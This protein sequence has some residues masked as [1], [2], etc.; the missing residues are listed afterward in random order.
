MI[1]PLHV[2]H[3]L[4]PHPR[5]KEWLNR[6]HYTTTWSD[7]Q[8]YPGILD[9]SLATKERRL[10]PER[11]CQ[12]VANTGELVRSR[13]ATIRVEAIGAKVPSAK[14][15][16]DRQPVAW[17]GMIGLRELASHD[18][19]GHPPNAC[20]SNGYENTQSRK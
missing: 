8:Y 13:K 9:C 10:V 14:Y 12:E 20:G 17:Q 5:R 4:P 7:R 19:G 3:A 15:R 11:L 18:F 16:S 1:G 2:A 6:L